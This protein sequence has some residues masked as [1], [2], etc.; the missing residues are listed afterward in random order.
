M[1]GPKR[2][3]GLD[4]EACEYGI[5]WISVN[6]SLASVVRM[7]A[8][9]TKTVLT[10][11]PMTVNTLGIEKPI[12]LVTS[13]LDSADPLC[14]DLP[15]TSLTILRIKHIQLQTATPDGHRR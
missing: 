6:V 2:E 1:R 15:A 5:D 3:R 9:A 12:L 4:L 11:D 14:C 13:E 8:K 7:G 10:G